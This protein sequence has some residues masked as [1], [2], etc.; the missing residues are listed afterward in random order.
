MMT[1]A[2]NLKELKGY[3]KRGARQHRPRIESAIHLYEDNTISK[4]KTTLNMVLSRSFY[5]YFEIQP[6]QMSKTKS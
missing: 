4:L 5:N 1:F 2:N 3:L 6:R